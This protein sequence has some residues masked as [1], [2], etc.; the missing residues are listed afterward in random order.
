MSSLY[1]RRRITNWVAMGLSMLAT[2]VG[3]AF[4]AWI[5]W[6]TLRQG[7]AAL[8]FSLFTKITANGADGGLANAMV[9]SLVIN[10]I[11]IAV[12]TP[13][14][15]LAGAWLA[16]YANRTKLGES[17]RFLNDILLSAP[18]IVIGLFVYTIV[19]L[20]TTALTHGSTTFSGFAGGIALALIA[21]PVIVRTTDEML[22]LVPSTLREAALSLG[23]PQ[24]KLTVQILIR[25]ARSGIITGVLLA[26]ARIS[27]ETAPL[28][29]TAFGNNYM[30]INP[31][32][33]MSSLP[34]IIYQYANDPGDAM[35]S[36]AWAGA[37]VVTM[38]VLLLSLASRLVLS[39]N[40]VS[41]E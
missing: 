20:P 36:M 8:N 33:K 12:A 37:F 29:F 19:V 35:H 3:L 28:L 6:E 17:I 32:D 14:G 18:S 11:G 2:L 25:A 31:I 41:H 30:A 39:R 21:L 27:G 34:Q 5:L 16:E 4:L 10:F 9:G 40:K 26:L 22:R 38:F 7:I 24:W 1:L 13:I 15:V 23:V